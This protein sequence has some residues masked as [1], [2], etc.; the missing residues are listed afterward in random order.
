MADTL[1]LEG[2]RQHPELLEPCPCDGCCHAQRCKSMRLACEAFGVFMAGAS[3]ARW[4]VVHRAPTRERYR[5]LLGKDIPLERS[6]R[7][8]GRHTPT[9]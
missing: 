6:N 9:P 4:R 3:P 5:E 8:L 2:A 1:V 7:Q